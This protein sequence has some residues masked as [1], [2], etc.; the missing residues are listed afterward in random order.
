MGVTSGRRVLIN[1]KL[2]KKDPDRA[3]AVSLITDGGFLSEDWSK[4]GL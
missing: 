4:Y 3:V 2:N 1:D